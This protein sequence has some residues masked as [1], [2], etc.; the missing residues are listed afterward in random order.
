MSQSSETVT[1]NSGWLATTPTLSVLIPFFRNDPTPLARRLDQEARA[2]DGRVEIVM[3]DDGSGYPTLTEAV[4]ATVAAL[5]TPTRLVTLNVNEGR[6][7]GRNRLAK[8]SRS[9]RLLFLDSD[10]APD[11]PDFLARYLAT[12]EAGDPPVV[13]GGFSMKQ[14][15]AGP[16]HALHVAL[17]QRAECLPVNMRVRHPEK[18][19]FTSNL[20]VRRDVFETET[21]DEGFTGWGWEDVEWGMRVARRYGVTH[22]DNTATH[23]GLDTADQLARKY[24]QSASNFARVVAAHA[25]IVSTYPSYRLAKVIRRFPARGLIRAALKRVAVGE[26]GPLIARV[27]AMKAYRAA[28]YAEVVS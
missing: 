9:Q 6:A 4:E 21:F 18:Y 22:I 3:L 2:L 12:I 11:A 20:L 10:M 15:S 16:A 5:S 23:L 13:F 17:A 8:H 24:E 7:R 14:I 25:E 27:V 26:R 19:V 1:D 28:L